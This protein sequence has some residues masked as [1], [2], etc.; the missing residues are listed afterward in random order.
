MRALGIDIGGSSVKAA[1]IDGDEHRTA[2]SEGYIRPDRD[3][4]IRAI[5]ET[6][7]GF[8]L[9]HDE[10]IPVGL[11]LPG[12]RAPSGDRIERSFNLPCLE[13]WA[14]RD[15]L[16]LSLDFEP[17]GFR[18]V[19]DID[20]TAHDIVQ[21]RSLEGRVAVVSIGT[22]IGMSLIEDGSVCVIGGRGIGHI[23][24]MDVGRIG[25]EDR[26]SPDGAKNTLELFVG[27]A[28]MR[29]RFSGVHD[30]EIVER[31]RT[32]PDDDACIVALVRALRIVHAIYVPD[33]IVLAGGFGML[34]N[35]RGERIQ[36]LISHGL[37]RLANPNW[38]LGFGDSLHH[39]ALGAARLA[40][41]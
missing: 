36:G 30:A 16:G 31:V 6:V 15:L 20:A 10:A 40:L 2:R 19:S 3:T 26:L 8:E 14:F 22:G 33:V 21:S 9:S 5:R 27:L 7:G 38:E 23:G 39:A 41:G 11:C 4:L 35:D 25:D 1:L 13:G 12:R 29:R 32:L 34:L 28:A 24:Q 37:T 17:L 18:I